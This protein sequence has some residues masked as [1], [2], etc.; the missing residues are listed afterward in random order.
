MFDI[1][2]FKN[3]SVKYR[4]IPF[5]SLNGKLTKKELK[6]QILNM[7]KMGFGGAFLHS[8]TGLET[9]YMSDE[10]MDL[11]DYCKDVLLENGMQVYLYDED[12]YPSGTCGGYV[13]AIKENKEKS[14]N[15]FEVILPQDFEKPDEFLGLFA[16]KLGKNKKCESYRKIE[17][18]TEAKEGE[19]VF[20]FYVYYMPD[21]PFY[22]GNCMIDMMYRP[23]TD[24]FIE[25]T[26]EQYKK[27]FGKLF[28]TDIKGIFTDEPCRG[29]MF[30]GFSHINPNSENLIPYTYKL[31]EEFSNRKGYKLEDK[32]PELWFGL[33]SDDFVKTTYDYVE[34]LEE[35]FLENFAVPYSEWCKKNNLKFVGHIL[36]EDNLAAQ[37]ILS[38]SM[39]RFYEYFDYPGMD[40]L[41]A[42][43]YC[44]NVPALVNSVAKQLG[45]EYV[46]D[47]LYGV[48]G[49]P[50]KLED[51]KR[52]GDW[53]TMG[54]V[55]LRVP[56]LC[57][58]TMKGEAKRDCPASIF[59]QSAWYLDYKNVEDYFARTTY[60]LKEGKENTD[61][62]II[63][64]IES[65]WGLANQYSYQGFF[66]AIQEPFVRLE[67]EYAE[68]YKGLILNGI[69]PDYIDEGLLVKYGNVSKDVL[70]C[71]K[72]NYKTIILNANLNLRKTTL[73]FINN[74][75][76][77][78]GKVIVVGE[79]PSYLDGKKY[80][81]KNDLKDAIK[82]DFD[83]NK[84][85]SLLDKDIVHCS[86][87]N[88]IIQKRMF[89]DDIFVLALNRQDVPEKVEIRVK[90]I[91][92]PNILNLRTGEISQVNY[93]INGDE[94]V[95]EK[96]FEPN[97]ELALYFSEK[98]LINEYKNYNFEEVKFDNVF[99]YKLLEDNFLVLNKCKLFLDDKFIS[100]NYSI[101]ADI[102]LRKQLG[103]S[104]RGNQMLQPW[105]QDKF[106]PEFNKKYGVVKL[107]YE[108]NV[109]YIPESLRLMF[110]YQNGT[111]ILLNNH[112]I[113]LSNKIE[114]EID[115]CFSLV[116]LPVNLFNKGLNTIDIIFDYYY[117]SNIEDHYLMGQFGVKLGEPDTMIKLPDKLASGNINKQG[118][119]YFGGK[120]LLEKDLENGKYELSFN[121]M[122]PACVSVNGKPINFPPYNTLFDVKDGKVNIELTYTRQNCFGI[123]TVSNIIE[124]IKEQ[125][126]DNF[127]LKKII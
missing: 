57:W 88:M 38:G 13:S 86:S 4:S 31:F 46:L 37:V 82:I 96:L 109:N 105:F 19:R 121:K 70:S 43:N 34:V 8:R 102:E 122:E 56:H 65:V 54:G 62:A 91:K 76:S 92:I 79:M 78:G 60:L 110:E 45:K 103:L 21:D 24:M 99:D 104:P 113:D 72:M 11:M 27:R 90:T 44:Y 42:N 28:G 41:G 81:F 84:L 80:D 49:W 100:E 36:H 87:Q 94:I 73:N 20:C 93:K 97:E 22:N 115:C 9:E 47:E 64:P 17:K 59:H 114:S 61:I 7:K 51:Y 29:P 53:Q 125:G 25:S 127:K 83:I 124:G 26:H 30:T 58:Y 2:E 68:L 116:N 71:G 33:E 69:N 67:K 118:L 101:Y 95:F 55:T 35:L 39:M 126:F 112:D 98:T 18:P 52:I 6:R 117:K 111:R 107:H 75:I 123:V 32:L 23:A 40:N 10:W 89:D 77:N 12:R 15:Y 5:W 74:F 119:P 66:D 16:V 108:F 1:K 106:Y 48:S 14:M 3:P 85:I 50:M 63:N 120:I